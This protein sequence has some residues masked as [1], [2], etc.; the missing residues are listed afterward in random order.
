MRGPSQKLYCESAV[1]LLTT[2]GS[3]TWQWRRERA[4]PERTAVSA[5]RDAALVLRVA[6]CG[7]RGPEI[8]GG[9]DSGAPAARASTGTYP[10]CG[11]I[12]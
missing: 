5:F 4:A 8:R 2:F 1:P 10:Q 11:Y 12:A 9:R 7:G 6:A 3:G